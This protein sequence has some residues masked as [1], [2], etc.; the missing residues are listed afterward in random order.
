[1]LHEGYDKNRPSTTWEW[2]K[3]KIQSAPAGEQR[4]AGAP[5]A[6]GRRV[7]DAYIPRSVTF[8]YRGGP[9]SSWVFQVGS[10]SWRYP[11]HLCLDDVL[12]HLLDVDADVPSWRSADTR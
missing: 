7:R 3:V 2:R 9:E 4:A 1:M 8:R 10:R 12:R 5:Q 6:V 11:G